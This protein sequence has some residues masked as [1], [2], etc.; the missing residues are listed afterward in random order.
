MNILYHDTDNGTMMHEILS[1][2]C[3]P[4]Y[5]ENINGYTKDSILEWLWLSTL[6]DGL[7][8]DISNDFYPA[9]PKGYGYMSFACLPFLK[10]WNGL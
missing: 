8:A 3:T 1:F 4:S 10:F 2:F 7:G 5:E 9:K 6:E